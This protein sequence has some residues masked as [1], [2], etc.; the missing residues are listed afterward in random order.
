MKAAWESGEWGYDLDHACTEYGG[1]LFR[2]VCLMRD[3]AQLLE[4]QYQRRRWDPVSRTEI[5]L[6]EQGVQNA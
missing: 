4:M 2:S 1:C 5:V 6:D 3:P